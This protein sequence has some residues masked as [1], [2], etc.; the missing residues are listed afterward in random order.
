MKEKVV[1]LDLDEISEVSYEN[2]VVSKS[3]SE[4]VV[5]LDL[6]EI[7]EVRYENIVVERQVH[8]RVKKIG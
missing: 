7:L 5:V 1:V 8:V 3:C 6:D 2:I 4:K